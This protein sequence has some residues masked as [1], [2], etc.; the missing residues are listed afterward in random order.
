MHPSSRS[1]ERLASLEPACDASGET[2]QEIVTGSG[3]RDV[4]SAELIFRLSDMCASFPANRRPPLDDS[5]L[6]NLDHLNCNL[7]LPL[8]FSSSRR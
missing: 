7:R 8:S 3:R 6:L 5:S 4:T 2:S 1:E